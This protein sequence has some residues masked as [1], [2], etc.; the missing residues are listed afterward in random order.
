MIESRELVRKTLEFDSPQR[1]PRQLWL[2]PWAEIHYPAESAR[3]RKVYPDDIAQAPAVYTKPPQLSGGKYRAGIYID[4]WGCH[5][6]NKEEGLMGIVHEPLIRE[7]SEL[8]RFKAPESM[9]SIDK[10]AI[11]SFCRHTDRFVYAGSIVR[12]LERFQFIRTMEQSFMDV[13]L[14]EPGYLELLKILHEHFCKE[15]EVW[16]QT[17][18]DAVFLMDDWGTQHQMM[19]S[20]EIFRKHFKPMYRDY[21]NI[22]HHYGKYVFMHS[23]GQIEEIIP[24]L[25]EVGVDALNS[26]LFC[27]DFERLGSIAAGKITFWGEIDRQN[28]LP[29]A[30]KQEIFDAVNTVKHYLYK[31]GGIIAQCEFGPAAKAENVEAVFE[32][33]GGGIVRM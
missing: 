26:Q 31:N 28:L 2:L 32:A 33:W 4:E 16:S 12:P 27:M 5:F 3:I 13:M 24:D 10:E 18:V 17:E 19:L 1:I 14:E 9:L 11:N 25:I 15:V 20:P 8:E 29:N 6:D 22:A 21:C 7:W 23:D 30:T